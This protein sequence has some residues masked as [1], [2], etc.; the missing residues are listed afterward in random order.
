MVRSLTLAHEHMEGLAHC[1][2]EHAHMLPHEWHRP[3]LLQ[4]DSVEA[5]VPPLPH[6]HIAAVL[7]GQRAHEGG[8]AGLGRPHENGD[9]LQGNLGI[10]PL[11]DHMLSKGTAELPEFQHGMRVSVTGLRCLHEQALPI[12]NT[13]TDISISGMA[14]RAL[15]STMPRLACLR[16]TKMAT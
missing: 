3:R 5:D 10:Q 11:K 2:L 8:F 16:H 12:L 6:V 9:A 4:R 7:T 15:V 1:G 14:M 13:Y